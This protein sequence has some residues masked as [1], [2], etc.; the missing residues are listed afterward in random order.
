MAE[1]ND[2]DQQVQATLNS[3]RMCL[4]SQRAS[5]GYVG[6]HGHRLRAHLVL[7][8]DVD[9]PGP[10]AVLRPRRVLPLPVQPAG[11]ASV[12]RH[13]ERLSIC[14]G[15]PARSRWPAS[16]QPARARHVRTASARSSS[17]GVLPGHAGQR[18][19]VEALAVVVQAEVNV[20]TRMV[21]AFRACVAILTGDTT[22]TWH[23][24]SGELT[25]PAT[26]ARDR[27]GGGT[28]HLG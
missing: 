26:W 3:S 21:S 24:M 20:R 10:H 4:K 18:R 6:R 15:G 8:H 28:A 7:R 19:D 1:E 11:D 16:F 2:A 25:H 23:I 27:S 12:S 13:S 22:N 17:T 5:F 9:L 14:S